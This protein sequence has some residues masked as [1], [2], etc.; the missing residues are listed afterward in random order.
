MKTIFLIRHAK[1]SWNNHLLEDHQRPLNKRGLSDAPMMGEL[2][3]K[4]FP[5]P[6]K[7]ICSTA[8]RAKETAEIIKGVWFPKKTIDFMDLLY[9]QPASNILSLIQ[10]IQKE[11]NSL[12][13]FFHNPTITY[14]GNLLASLSISN[15]PT[16]GVLILSCKEK[17]W[18]SVEV[19]NCE[20]ISF[21][22]P[23]E[24]R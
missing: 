22:Y 19:G 5:P 3:K 13:L 16:C 1:S 17:N 14:L 2:L 18:G 24:I 12:A 6:E 9:E 15:I 8:H 7:I 23:K 10:N 21:N 4:E 20:L 11:I